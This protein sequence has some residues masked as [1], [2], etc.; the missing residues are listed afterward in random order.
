MRKT[1]LFLLFLGYSIS[2]F[3]QQVT[4]KPVL[5][6]NTRNNVDAY[7]V[8]YDKPTGSYIY[9][10]YDTTT[11]KNTIMTSQGSAGPYDYAASYDALFDAQG[12]VYTYTYNNITDTTFNYFLLK[13]NQVAASY[14]MINYGWAIKNGIIYYSAVDNG[15][16]SLYQY[17]TA[18]GTI[19][20]GKEY[21][22]ITF[23]SY[24]QA[25]SEG[26]A[27][28]TIGFTNDGKVYYMASSNNEKFMVIGDEEQKHYSDIDYYNVRMDPSGNLT[29]IA[30]DM[31]KFY[32]TKGNT[33]VVQGTKEYKK[34][35]YV[36]G[37]VI[38]DK[39]NNAVYY[40]SDSVSGK[41]MCKV[42]S[43]NSEIKTF[44]G[45]VYSMQM[46]PGG[47]LAYVMSY[48]A[49]P[50]QV[51]KSAIVVD[52]KQYKSYENMGIITFPGNDIPMYSAGSTDK[53]LLY[54]GDEAISERYQSIVDG[55]ILPNGKLEYVG[56]N[57]GNYDRKQSDKYY[58]HMGDDKFGPFNTINMIDYT[59]SSYVLADNS[60]NYAFVGSKLKDW[61]SY[62]M[63]QTLYT[64]KGK[65]PVFDYIDFVK[66]YNGKPFYI[67]T[68]TT[69][70][71]NNINK[72]R[73]YYD[74]KPATPDYDSIANYNFDDATGTF[75]F[76]G[77]KG[78]QLYY[79]EVKL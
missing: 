73:I 24:P 54:N 56:V 44:E 79:V 28:G 19:K 58:L 46:T 65:S 45:N 27:T 14:T 62:T 17:N 43:G 9:T 35:D 78:S 38:F 67:G 59:N 68:T 15:H 61:K 40:A 2:L 41:F 22:T 48:P 75:S 42:V 6:V 71:K 49:A 50:D 76:I 33:F 36:Y 51:Y 60:G 53:S 34:Y 30:R 29:Y 1:S 70:R 69:D 72:Q 57:Y 23:V 7:S 12:N 20:K 63:E 5:N 26:E 8:K 13:N 10:D 37:P 25:P 32:D 39:N 74:N 11:R 55:R 77:A 18:D 21:D 47:K 64:N 3:A 31:G 66:L 52:G 16:A 4:E